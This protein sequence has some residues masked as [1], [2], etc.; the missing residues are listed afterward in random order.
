MHETISE[1]HSFRISM[2]LVVCENESGKRLALIST[3]LSMSAIEIVETYL[4]R[5]NIETYFKS[6]QQDFGLGK[7]KLKTDLR[8]QNWM[9]LIKLAYLIF[10]EH[11]EYLIAIVEKVSKQHV[12]MTIQD[13]LSRLSSNLKKVKEHYDMLE[14]DFSMKAV[15]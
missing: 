12:F 13:A 11:M 1:V 3:D 8:Q 4:E 5:W 7:C 10:K 14:T 6:A 2:K 9:I 15:T